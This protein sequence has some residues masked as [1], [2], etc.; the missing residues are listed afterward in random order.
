MSNK[1][2][3][4]FLGDAESRD[5]KGK[6]EMQ[7]VRG[8]VK[9]LSEASANHWINRGM[10]IEGA[11]KLDDEDDQKP[12]EALEKAAEALEKS[13]ERLAAAKAVPLTATGAKKELD[14]ATKHQAKK[15]QEYDALVAESEKE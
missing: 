2:E 15:Q 10:A 6:I 4:T 7:A 9:K 12:D 14:L 3:I 11:V 13:N 1:V 5:H 8:D